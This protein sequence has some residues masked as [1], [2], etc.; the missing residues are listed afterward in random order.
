MTI[1]NAIQYSSGKLWALP[2]WPETVELSESC[3]NHNQCAVI[4]PSCECDMKFLAAR[5][6][7]I[8]GRVEFKPTDQIDQII[9]NSN[10]RD[11]DIFPGP[12]LHKI[13]I[14]SEPYPEPDRDMYPDFHPDY[15]EALAKW[16]ACSGIR[17]YALL[18]PIA[19][20]QT[21]KPLQPS[22][23]KEMTPLEELIKW[24]H[25]E[26]GYGSMNIDSDKIITKAASLLPRERQVIETAFLEGK[27][28]GRENK[29]GQA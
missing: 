7:S 19:E 23:P 2:D 4:D 11:G 29:K 17:T 16:K 27:I 20:E 22:Q 21:S 26:S 3:K 8:K 18:V 25:F 15:D 13:K 6:A 12:E 9:K 10:F 28:L 14:K 5:E 24:L 1:Y